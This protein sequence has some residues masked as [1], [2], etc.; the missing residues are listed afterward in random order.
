MESTGGEEPDSSKANPGNEGTALRFFHDVHVIRAAI[1]LV[2][3]GVGVTILKYASVILIPV[4]LA[5]FLS[6]L[7]NPFVRMLM[8][9]RIPNTN[10]N[11]PRGVASLIMVLVAVGFAVA[12]G[13]L[14]ADQFGSFASDV[15]RH[16]DQISES[17]NDYQERVLEFQ[18]RA[19][20]YF[21][22]IRGEQDE[23]REVELE[24][25]EEVDWGDFPDAS[26]AE[27]SLFEETS[28]LWMRASGYIAGGLTG[29]LGTL[30]QAL[31]C[32]FVL[33]FILLDSPSIRAKVI[34]I[35]GTTANRREKVLEVLE[36][37]NRD[38][39][40]YVF[41]R[42]AIN[43]VLAVVA[44]LVYWIYGLNYALLLGILAGLFN[45]VPYVGP[46]VGT[47]FPALVAYL[48]FGTVESVLWVVF[49]Y[50]AMTGIEGNM[51]TP[52]VLGRHL[53]LN[54]LAVILGL[55]FWGWLWG[56]IGLLLAIPILAAIKAIAVHL[57][58]LHPVAELLRA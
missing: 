20:R 41:V 2:A 52:L 15:A 24:G 34:G 9:F 8:R 10:I 33:Y 30:A 57:E 35:V 47:I 19:E 26:D 16:R 46:F 55:V 44:T 56:A 54:S 27:E 4:M 13:L 14:I 31:T 5:V 58:D 38:V 12:L 51:I 49:L 18:E 36:N 32:I 39:Q 23:V 29:L 11:M 25:D 48:Q 7:L 53:E 17:V 50:G 45:F 22:P 42:F 28:Q 43:S 40:R 37:V 21:Q 1:L 6:Y 3:F